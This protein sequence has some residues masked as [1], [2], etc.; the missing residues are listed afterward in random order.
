MCVCVYVCARARL[1]LNEVIK[2][3]GEKKRGNVGARYAQ[4]GD[5]YTARCNTEKYSGNYSSDNNELA[6]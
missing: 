1:F 2:G 6:S 5:N 4:C 3:E